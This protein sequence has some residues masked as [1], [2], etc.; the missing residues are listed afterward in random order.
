MNE[1]PVKLI[2]ERLRADLFY[3]LSVGMLIAT[4]RA[5]SPGRYPFTGEHTCA[6]KIPRTTPQR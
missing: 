5:P 6:D 4:R 3:R 2:Q 1:A